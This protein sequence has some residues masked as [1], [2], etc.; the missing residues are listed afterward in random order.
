M[1][2]LP[3]QL[4]DDL[5]TSDV[6]LLCAG[7][8]ELDLIGRYS[9]NLCMFYFIPEVATRTSVLVHMI[10]SS[11]YLLRCQDNAITVQLGCGEVYLGR[12]VSPILVIE[13]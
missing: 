5:A 13:C 10:L 12:A 4:F 11:R 8:S 2:Q 7:L 6:L 9:L 1:A 3:L